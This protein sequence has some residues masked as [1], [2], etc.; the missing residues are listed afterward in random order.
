MALDATDDDILAAVLSDN[1]IGHGELAFIRPEE[2]NLRSGEFSSAVDEKRYGLCQDI[3]LYQR[4][5]ETG[6]Y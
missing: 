6:P 5:R 1:K 3:S 2:L 4:A